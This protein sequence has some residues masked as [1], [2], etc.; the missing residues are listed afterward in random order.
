MEKLMTATEIME[1]CA[2]VDEI[3]EEWLDKL[4]DFFVEQVRGLVEQK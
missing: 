3:V 4:T 1:R 2:E